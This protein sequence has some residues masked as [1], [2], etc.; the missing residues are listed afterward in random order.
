MLTSGKST[1][2]GAIDGWRRPAGGAILRP[3]RF[4]I[5]PHNFPIGVILMG[6]PGEALPIP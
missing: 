5:D 6:L 1:A 2:E 3:V 4:G